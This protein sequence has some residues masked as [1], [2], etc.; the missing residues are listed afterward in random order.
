MKHL[1]EGVNTFQRDHFEPNRETFRKLTRG[2][3]PS[4]LFITCSDSRIDPNLLTQTPPGELFVLR[5]A[6]NMVPAHG[7]VPGGG[8]EATVEY[9]MLELG[10]R[11]VV[12]MG[13]SGCGA[14]G[15]LLEQEHLNGLPAVSSW[16]A[17][18]QGARRSVEAGASYDG[19]NLADAVIEA[20]V[21]LQLENLLTHPSVAHRHAAG[22]VRLHGWV[23]GIGDG[24]VRAHD[25]GQECFVSLTDDHAAT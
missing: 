9:A 16:L 7:T 14:M 3:E 24:H 10:V 18:A 5:N 20:N 4:A 1:I 22:E 17:H 21:L 12:V 19:E 8:E 23:Y 6:G 25:A 11:E 2:Q 13:H 15:A